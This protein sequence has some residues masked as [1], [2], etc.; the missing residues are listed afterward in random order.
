MPLT[1]SAVLGKRGE[2]IARH[3]LLSKGYTILAKNYR[4]RKGE[5]DL[6]AQCGRQ[7]VAVE[8]KSRTSLHYGV[9]EAAISEQKIE[10]ISATAGHFQEMRKLE[11]EIRFDVITIYFP[12]GSLPRL[13]HIRDAFHG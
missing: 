11:L 3:Y 12:E 5:I 8:V 9:P 1:P 7:L 13:L 2:A 4:H 10:L 6:I